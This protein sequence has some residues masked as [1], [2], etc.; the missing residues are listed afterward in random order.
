MPP[1][2]EATEP[3]FD[4]S[5]IRVVRETWSQ[6]IRELVRHPGAAAVV[7]FA[8]DDVVLVRQLRQSIR[9]VTLEI[10]A[11]ILDVAGETPAECAARELHEETG[12]RAADLDHLGMIHTSLGFTDERI[13]LFTCTAIPGGEPEE[14]G[15]AE[16]VVLS[17]E[18]AL[19]AV[20]DGEITD[21]KSVAALLL[22]ADAT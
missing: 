18:E 3:I 16:V 8:G 9:A 22:A 2:P 21:A 6:G 20:R 4:G 17:L 12:Y 7:A 11:G 19:Q 13:E 5:L 1:E 15:I 10:P 14:E